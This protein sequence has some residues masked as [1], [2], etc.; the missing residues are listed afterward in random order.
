VDTVFKM[1][2]DLGNGDKMIKRYGNPYGTQLKEDGVG[3]YVL[4]TDYMKMERAFRKLHIDIEAEFGGGTTTRAQGDKAVED[5]L[6]GE[7]DK[8]AFTCNGEPMSFYGYHEEKK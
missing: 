8:T 1:A 5:V 7:Y 2:H 6:V 4:F 3:I